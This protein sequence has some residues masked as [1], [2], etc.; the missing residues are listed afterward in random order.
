VVVP[1]PLPFPPMP[2]YQLWHERVHDSDEVRWLRGLVA[3]ATRTLLD[4]D[5]GATMRA[6]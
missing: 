6:A 3:D 4:N 5:G 1:A 2:Y